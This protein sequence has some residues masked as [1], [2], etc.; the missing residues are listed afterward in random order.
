MTPILCALLSLDKLPRPSLSAENG[1]LVPLG[2]N[3]TLKC[4]GSW[5]ADLYRLVKEKGSKKSKIT[6]VRAAGI[7]L[8]FP[9]SYVTAK[10]AGTYHCWYRHSFI[11]SEPSDPLELVVTG[12]IMNPFLCALLS[13]GCWVGRMWELGVIRVLSARTVSKPEDEDTGSRAENG[14]LVRQGETVTLKCK[15]SR[16]ADEWRLEKKLRSKRWKIMD[17]RGPGTG[18]EFSLPSVAWMDAGT[19]HCLYSHSSHWSKSSDPLELVV[20]GHYDRPSLLARPSSEVASG[21]NVTLQ[22]WTD[23]SY[24]WS[25]L[26]K[27]GEK[28]TQSQVLP[29]FGGYKADF[30][31]LDVTSMH[32]GTYQ[33]YNFVN[34]YPDGV[35]ATSNPLVLRVTGTIMNPFLCALLSLGCWVGRMWE[36]G[37]IRV[38]SARAVSGPEDED[39][40]SRAENGPLVRQGETVTLRC[41]G[42]RKADEWRLEKKLRSK[43]WKIM[44]VRGP[45]TGVEFSLPSVAWMDAG[46]YH[47]LY[48]HSSH[49]SKSSDPLQ[50]VVT[51]HYDRPSLLARPSSEVASGQNV[52]LQCWTDQSYDW[53]VLYKDGE[54]LTQ[55][56]V[57]P[58]LGRYKADFSILDVTSMHGGTYQ[59]YN[60]VNDYPD[61]VSATSNPLVL[62]VTDTTAQD[63][64]VNNLVRLILSGLV[65]ILLGVLLIEHW[66]SSRKHKNQSRE[67]LS[68]QSGQTRPGGR[69]DV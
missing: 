13:L 28:L 58:S 15:G 43:K 68:E 50:L 18:V 29:S 21:Q 24:D 8:E 62:R 2:E 34:D 66:K 64:T 16:K 49:W 4:R 53:S 12:T 26:Y 44:D 7:E 33:C 47:C 31:I 9:I 17:V 30:S 57:L 38:L 37:V 51:G 69:P 3:V 63:Y 67:P 6:D 22:C 65:L 14:P 60:F 46:T 55:S 56:Q 23:Q 54:K 19:Y 32:G 25:V 48:S 52:T 41:K 1:S 39:T 42:S 5:E 10:D 35:S 36:L 40:G 27:D 59:C 11:W 45:G 61:G 20:T